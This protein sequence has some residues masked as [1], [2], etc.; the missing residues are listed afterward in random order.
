[1]RRTYVTLDGLRGVAALS[2]VVLHCYRYFGDFTWSS[3]ALAVDLF[4]VLSG[5]VL[6]YAY[7][8]T[9]PAA[10]LSFIRARLI[11]LYPLYL[12]GTLL[13][14]I[15]SIAILQS[16]LGSVTW[17]W[18]QF[19]TSLPF[20]LVMLPAPGRTLFP[21][22]G[23]MWSIFFELFINV[24]WAIFWR[25]LQSTRTLVLVTIACGMGLA[26]SC[27]YWHTFTGLGTGWKSFVGG[28]FRVGYSF[29]LGVLFF[30]YHK[31]L[32]LPKLP[33]ILLLVCLPAVL[34][35]RLTV[36]IELAVAMFILPWFVLL[37]SQV[38][39]RGVVEV[40]SRQLGLA[41]YAVYAMHKRLYGLSY[42]L[43]FMIGLDL[44]PFAPWVGI[45]FGSALVIGCLIVNRLYD[46]PARR[47]LANRFRTPR[48]LTAK[49][50]AKQG[51]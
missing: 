38:E 2:I 31:M 44:Q 18:T 1:V 25:P 9:L 22:N 10:G 48:R 34:F 39:P 24:V 35:L 51:P 17:T 5:F 13:G 27:A 23:V 16:G 30:R 32:K 15:E 36:Y 49:E 3:A 28:T 29:F 6:A 8:A 33:P 20:A 11:R 37:G 7:E 19:W 43:L 50:G 4:F 42:G 46:Q 45:M 21:F 41:S 47:W 14:V 26:V 12:L 40:V